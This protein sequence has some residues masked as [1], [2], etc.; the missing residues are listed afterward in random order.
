MRLSKS[1]EKFLGILAREVTGKFSLSLIRCYGTRLYGRAGKTK[2][3]DIA[4]TSP[5]ENIQI[6]FEGEDE[7][8]SRILVE[9]LVSLEQ[10]TRKFLIKKAALRPG[11]KIKFSVAGEV[12]KRS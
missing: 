4:F 6:D 11:F 12:H 1:K 10:I 5:V 3:L 8:F 2:F 7:K 9:L